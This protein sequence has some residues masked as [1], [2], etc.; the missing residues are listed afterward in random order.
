M[1]KLYYIFN[2]LLILMIPTLI[3]MDDTE[4]SSLNIEAKSLKTSK[5]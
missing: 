5:G 2:L 3:F 1:K 4:V